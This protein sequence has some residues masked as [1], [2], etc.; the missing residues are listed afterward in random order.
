MKLYVRVTGVLFGLVAV[1]HAWR[2]L[3]EGRQLTAQPVFMALTV[4]AAA[5]AVWAWRAQ[6]R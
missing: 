3:R 6:A 1:E 2:I 5:L 4:A